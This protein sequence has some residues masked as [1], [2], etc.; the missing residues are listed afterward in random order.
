MSDKKKDIVTII[1]IQEINVLNPRERNNKDFQRLVKNIAIL[2]LKQPITV[3]P[4]NEKDGKGKFDLACGQGRLEAYITLGQTEIPAII[5][6]MTVE[7]CLLKSLVENLARRQPTTMEKVQAIEKLKERGYNY[8]EIARKIDLP[9]TY[10]QGIVRLL[11]Q[12]EERL[13]HAVEKGIMPISIAVDIAASDNEGV[14]LALLEAYESKMLRG[15]KLIKARKVITQRLSRGKTLRSGITR[16]KKRGPSANDVVRT[17]RRE[18]ERQKFITK[19]AKLCETRLIFIVSG[20]KELFENE[21]FVTLLQA[22]ALDTLPQ[23]LANQI[24]L[25][26]DL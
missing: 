6:D 21:N 8:S 15:S 14:Q 4:R 11:K 5:E 25:K 26:G 24:N 2:G 12:G 7:D 23:Y 19:K 22:E 17:Y 13:L 3:S 1:P 18:I 10:V 16:G 20:L 9:S